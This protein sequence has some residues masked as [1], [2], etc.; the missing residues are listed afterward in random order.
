MEAA[1]ATIARRG[2]LQAPDPRA[3][4]RSAG[5]PTPPS[6]PPIPLPCALPSDPPPVHHGSHQLF[7]SSSLSLAAGLHSSPFLPTSWGAVSREVTVSRH[8][9]FPFGVG[10]RVGCLPLP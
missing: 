1:P 9:M 3:A 6:P 7:S 2:Q 5:F 4:S 8:F 10:A